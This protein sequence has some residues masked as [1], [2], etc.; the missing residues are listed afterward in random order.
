MRAAAASEPRHS[1]S[2]HTKHP[3]HS[4]THTHKKNNTNRYGLHAAEG[5]TAGA[6]WPG[7]NSVFGTRSLVAGTLYP[8]RLRM[9]ENYGAQ[10]VALYWRAP[11]GTWDQVPWSA[12]STHPA[13]PPSY[14]SV[15]TLGYPEP[16][17][18]AATTG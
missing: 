9:S 2:H 14:A 13:N 11:G 3:P 6:W 1:V 4:H 18:L 17:N 5:A 8:I 12:F 15:R 7:R 16:R 10:L